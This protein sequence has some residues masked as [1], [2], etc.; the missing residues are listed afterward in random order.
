MATDTVLYFGYGA[1][2]S[3]RVRARYVT[4][5]MPYL[6]QKRNFPSPPPP[7]HH[8]QSSRAMRVQEA[9]P[10]VAPNHFMSFS[11]WG[12]Y[13][14]IDPIPV[15]NSDPHSPSTSISTTPMTSAFTPAHGVLM[16]I[17]RADMDALVRSEIGYKLVI[18]DCVPYLPDRSITDIAHTPPPTPGAAPSVGV[19]AFAFQSDH[20]NRLFHPTYPQS[21]YKGKLVEGARIHGLAPEYRAKLERIEAVNGFAAT[22]PAAMDTPQ[23][24]SRAIARHGSGRSGGS[25]GVNRGIRGGG[26][27]RGCHT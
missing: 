19:P 9:W 22:P 12:A 11:H 1:N 21:V 24:P 3:P 26:Q 13:A 15:A 14:T 23:Y 20:G 2:M 18:I 5:I 8:P 27:C 4:C 25:R 16:R 10:A 7:H 17:P 6:I